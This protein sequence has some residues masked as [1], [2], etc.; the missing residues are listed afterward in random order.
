[1]WG[2][3]QQVRINAITNYF[4]DFVK[5]NINNSKEWFSSSAA[6]NGLFI[7]LEGRTYDEWKSGKSWYEES[8]VYYVDGI[9]IDG[10]FD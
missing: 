5:W 2:D 7:S 8:E 4:K 10:L 9:E 3:K 6:T 1:M